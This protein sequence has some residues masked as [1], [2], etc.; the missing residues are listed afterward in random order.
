MKRSVFSVAR[1]VWARPA[2]S[3]VE[4]AVILGLI[5]VICVVLLRG[6]GVTTNNSMEPVNKAF[7]P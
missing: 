1:R 5:A 7:E 3:V 4:Y 2:Q 6:I